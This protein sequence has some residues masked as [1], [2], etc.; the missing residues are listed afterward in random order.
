M[1]NYL[2]NDYPRYR[3]FD[4]AKVGSGSEDIGGNV[5]RPLAP[6]EQAS[7]D[8]SDTHRAAEDAH[9]LRRLD[10]DRIVAIALH[11]LLTK[12]HMFARDIDADEFVHGYAALKGENT[13]G[14]VRSLLD[15]IR[16]QLSPV[17]TGKA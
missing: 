8:E 12:A 4:D 9:R 7:R 17:V 2:T 3:Q 11:V 13:P 6:H 16:A 1:R 14:Y 15:E 10:R 5:L